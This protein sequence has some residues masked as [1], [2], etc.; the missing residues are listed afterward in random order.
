MKNKILINGF[1]MIEMLISMVVA[2]IVIM[3]VYSF[4]TSSQ[5][6]FTIVQANDSANRSMQLSNRS[7]NDYFKMAGFR[8]YRRVVD[9]V[10]FPTETLK[11]GESEKAVTFGKGETT[12]VQAKT[13][14]EIQNSAKNS[15]RH[16]IFLRFYGSSI[17]DDLNYT[18]HNEVTN[19]RI[20]DCRGDFRTNKEL[21]VINLYIDDSLG[22]VCEHTV[23]EMDA[24]NVSTIQRVA[25]R[26]RVVLDPNITVMMF[27]ARYDGDPRFFI[28]GE[29]PSDNSSATFTRDLINAI[30]YGF[31]VAQESHQKIQHLESD[32]EF[33]LLGFD[34]DADHVDSDTFAKDG[35]NDEHTIYNLVSG[36]AYMRNTIRE[37]E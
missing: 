26:A 4:L 23:Y 13:F 31:V 21:V 22:L 35:S 19:R 3:G 24:N 30:R 2:S 14:V 18:T 10:F 37:N 28:P 7:I 12:N 15:K 8:N 27:S 36:V 16:D 32:L 17:D 25:D 29:E 9:Y 20:Y 5:R 34:D 1:S 6:S 11:V 33:H